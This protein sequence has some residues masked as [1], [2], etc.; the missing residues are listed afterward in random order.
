MYQGKSYAWKQHL[1]YIWFNINWLKAQS[2]QDTG[3]KFQ[4]LISVLHIVF[5]P[6]AQITV[7]CVSTLE[8]NPGNT[9]VTQLS[10]EENSSVN[11]VD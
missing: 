11:K 5:V 1:Y 9:H 4:N 8:Y 7:V 6:C 10:C 2:R 3:W